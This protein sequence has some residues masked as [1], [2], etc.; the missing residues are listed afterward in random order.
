[1]SEATTQEEVGGFKMR[2]VKREVKRMFFCENGHGLVSLT[3]AHIQL[4]SKSWLKHKSC[5]CTYQ[6]IDWIKLKLVTDVGCT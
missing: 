6:I 5:R 1:M 4:L 2:N 3:P